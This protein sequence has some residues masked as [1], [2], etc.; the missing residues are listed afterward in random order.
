MEFFEKKISNLI[1]NQ[2]PDFYKEEGPAFIE[3]VKAYYAW[4]ESD[5]NAVYHARRLLE[6]RDID[7]TVDSFL[8]HFKDKYLSNFTF[9]TTVDTRNLVKHSLDLYRSKG[10]SRS[11]DLLFRSVFGVGASIYY[12]SADIFKTSSGKWVEPLYL[13]V[14]FYD[15]SASFE[16]MQIEGVDSGAVAFVERYVKKRTI[17][18]P[19]AT[20]LLYIS[21]LVGNFKTGEKIRAS[22][23]GTIGPVVIGSMNFLTVIDGSTGYSIGD[24]VSIKSTYNGIGG[25]ARVAN[26]QSIGG[27]VSF[28]LK[29]GGWGYNANSQ[30]L[31][32]Q[33]IVTVSGSS[34]STFK[35]FETVIE[36]M[37]NVAY[38]GLTGSQFSVGESAYRIDANTGLVYTQGVIIAV[39]QVSSTNGNIVVATGQ[40]HFDQIMQMTDENGNVLG[41]EDGF[42]MGA[43]GILVDQDGMIYVLP[44]GTDESGLTLTTEDGFVIIQSGATT[45]ANIVSM[46]DQSASG[47]VIAWSANV[48]IAVSNSITRFTNGEYVY[49]VDGN[50]NKVANGIIDLV[51]Y[52]GTNATIRLANTSGTFSTGTVTSSN[53][54]ASGYI[55]GITVDIGVISENGTFVAANNSTVF[56]LLSN[57]VGSTSRISTGFG[58]NASLS[59]IFLYNET[60]NV[61]VDKIGNYSSVLLNAPDY[62][63]PNPGAEN[64]NTPLGVA[65]T[66]SMGTY[67]RIFAINPT[68]F[69]TGYNAPPFIVAYEPNIAQFNKQDYIVNIGNTVGSFLIGEVILQSSAQIGLIKPGSNS[70]ILL[71][72]RL[73]IE[74]LQQGIP[75]VGVTS[76]AVANTISVAVDILSNPIGIDA[77]ITANTTSANGSVLT[78]EVTDSGFGYFDGEV[79]SFSTNTG[80]PGTA[81]VSSIKQGKAKGFHKENNSL[82]SADKYIQDGD[83]YQEFSYEIRSSITLDKY[84]DILKDIMH[85]AGT[86][87]FSRYVFDTDLNASVTIVSQPVDVHRD[88]LNLSQVYDSQYIGQ[89]I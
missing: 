78:L 9:D 69:G 48:D 74:D 85:I 41:Y 40:S 6:Y 23:T 68:N 27:K 84:S 10:T 80:T 19:L 17:G 67:G 18:S 62:G 66:Y 31:I 4:M 11:V 47:N 61:D 25:T 75:I 58:A 35:R 60:I 42:S 55:D 54:S 15:N 36:P 79:V 30:L 13:E 57:T 28:A 45:T 89:I 5:G 52:S 29:D 49:Q 44:A 59:S 87:H 33:N 26:T 43:D 37:Q 32:S 73:A 38:T 34:S 46:T 88:A 1:E 81:F 83:Y 21:N 39:N 16:N 51:S 71:V 2:F 3:F 50:G 72:Q 65:F 63:F 22:R 24:S 77:S 14:G 56:G 20:E 8:I 76:S 12:P 82:L 64:A 7:S 86:K 53:T 70:S